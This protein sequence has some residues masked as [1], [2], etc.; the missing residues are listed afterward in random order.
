MLRSRKSI[1]GSFFSMIVFDVIV[2][3]VDFLYLTDQLP[4]FLVTHAGHVDDG[5]AVFEKLYRVG[6][7][8]FL[9]G[10]LIEH[11]TR[12]GDDHVDEQT[13]AVIVVAEP[14]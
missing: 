12:E 13:V 5:A 3:V 1:V 7:D 14:L 10:M 4:E 6:D 11:R 9:A 2:P 8:F